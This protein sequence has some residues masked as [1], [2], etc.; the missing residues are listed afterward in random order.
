[1]E[2]CRFCFHDS[3]PS[4][5]ISPC[6]C[7]GTQHYIHLHCLRRWQATQL[8]SSLNPNTCS[9]CL[10]SYS[11]EYRYQLHRKNKAFPCIFPV[12]MIVF[13]AAVIY[14]FQH[15]FAVIYT[16]EGLRLAV[17]QHGEPVPDLH[18][19]FLLVAEKV[20]SSG[21]FHKSQVLILEYSYERGAKGVIINSLNGKGGPVHPLSFHILHTCE[22][23][24]GTVV[25]PGLYYQ[26]DY[27]SIMS[28]QCERKVLQG[29]AGWISGQLDGEIRAKH[30]SVRPVTDV[31]EVLRSRGNDG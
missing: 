5:L 1:M 11:S 22:G 28:M 27:D 21:I 12:L 16:N 4:A 2:Q 17:I 19:P 18:A 24:G 3:P 10:H 14:Q 7:T 29:F 26:G 20:I 30:W 23:A 13:T 15:R 25:L 6:A 31:G 8:S 9:T